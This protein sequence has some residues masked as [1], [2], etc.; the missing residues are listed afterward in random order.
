MS[1]IQLATSISKTT[2]NKLD[3]FLQKKGYRMNRFLED[4]ILARIEDEIE[5]RI[6]SDAIDEAK[7]FEILAQLKTR[8]KKMGKL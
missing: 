8:L 5:G 4:A 6:L 7:E 1:N 2:K 3:R